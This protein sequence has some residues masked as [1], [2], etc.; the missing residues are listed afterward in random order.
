MRVV[1][2]ED[3]PLALQAIRQKL[4][5]QPHV[6]VKFSAAH[7]HELLTRLQRDSVVDVVLMDIQMPVMDGIAA[8]REVKRLFPQI[9]ILMLTTFDDDD[10]IF[11]SILAGA[12]GYLL[13]D[14]SDEAIGRALTE[15]A[16]GGAAMSPAI[17]LKA[18]NLIRQPLTPHAIHHDFGLTPR[19]RAIL[20][21]LKNGLTYEAIGANLFISPGTVRKHIQH[22]YHKLQV[23]NKVEAVQKAVANRLVQ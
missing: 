15:T 9:K 2:A 13:K 1:I 22:I 14:E 20:E 18:L 19:E 16:E 4:A 12:S 3:N 17:A 23:N 5:L 6:Q 8:T 10:K 11:E 21:Q 7:G